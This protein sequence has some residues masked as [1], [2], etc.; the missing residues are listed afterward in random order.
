MK[1][2]KFGSVW[3]VVRLT[4][5]LMSN[6][7]KL[8]AS[9]IAGISIVSSFF[10]LAAI[11]SALPFI[12]LL[13]NPGDIDRIGPVVRIC[14]FLGIEARHISVNVLG[15]GVI[16]LLVAAA[17]FRIFANWAVEFFS[18][19]FTNAL[20]DMAIRRTIR[21]PYLWLKQ[22]NATI[23]SQRIMIDVTTLGQTVYSGVL[24]IVYGYTILLIGLAVIVSS[25]SPLAFVMV[26]IVGALGATVFLTLNP[27][28]ARQ[29][30]L[31]RDRLFE[32]GRLALEI[33]AAQKIIKAGLAENAFVRGFVKVFNVSS[34]ARLRMVMISKIVPI[35]TLFLGQIGMIAIAL[36]MYNDGVSADTLV[37]QLT[38]I[39]VIVARI[40]PSAAGLSGTTNKLTKAAPHCIAFHDSL[41]ALE[42]LDEA[43]PRATL[44]P[45]PSWRA[46]TAEH[47]YFRHLGSDR[48]QLSDVC[49]TIERGA[50]IGVVGR[51]GA[52]KSTL[53]DLML[54]LVEPARGALLLDGENLSNFETASWLS[55]IGYVAQ[56]ILIL[57][58]TV[59][60]NVA[61]GIEDGNIEDDQVWRVLEIAGLADE[62]RR[63]PS[64]LNSPL[65]EAGGRLSGGQRQRLAIARALY[66][67][68]SILLLD[69]AMSGLDQATE[70]TVLQNLLDL[71]QE[72]T[73]VMVTHRLST[74]AICDE[75]FAF[76]NG[77]LVA[78]GKY[79]QL[80]QDPAVAPLLAGD[81]AD[82]A[83]VN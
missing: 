48:D 20:I 2:G 16:I 77:E 42:A 45:V 18:L 3:H 1:A 25:A 41:I 69:E 46:F 66:R 56:E 22:Q 49:F 26:A 78:K 54:R 68:P 62:I 37:A 55:Q 30:A 50:R 35:F 80:M 43:R 73:L 34:L 23:L 83:L 79:A 15:I 38:L 63:L 39:V 10:E 19:R 29:S 81:N 61:F 13:M 36:T 52:G 33:F 57:D 9:L 67:R 74:T 53:V 24:D 6:R 72:M 65:G 21:G 60:R 82:G 58:D 8:A 4:W 64:G 71:P 76:S 5:S 59:R 7:Q 70:A 17:G 32:S 11:S 51:S 27:Q 31:Y 40:L 28:M 44:P 12:T 47:L 75:V 14:A